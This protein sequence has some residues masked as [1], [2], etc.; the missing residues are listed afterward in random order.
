MPRSTSAA[1]QAPL[2]HYRPWL[3]DI[4]RDKPH[5]LEDKLE[6]LFHEKA[7]T[8]R[9]AWIRLFDETITAL[10]FDVD[11]ESLALEPV[12]NLLQDARAEKRRA[13]AEALGTNAQ[14]ATS[15][16]SR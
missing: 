2:S 15:A 7:V 10:R 3:D 4:R 6:Q 8:G 14:G 11:G 1:A 13:A 9:A 16:P 5:Q 12:L